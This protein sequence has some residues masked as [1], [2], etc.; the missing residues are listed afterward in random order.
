MNASV[1]NETIE[2]DR[3]PL[4]TTTVMKFNEKQLA[5][6]CAILWGASMLVMGVANVIWHGYGQ[7]FLD[8]IASVYPG[9]HAVGSFLEVMIGTMYGILDGLVGG[10]VFAWLYNRLS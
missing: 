10:F 9:Y 4:P 6:A 1:V 5:F 2:S 7:G 3:K 8:V